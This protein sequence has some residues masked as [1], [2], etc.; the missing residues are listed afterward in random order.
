MF[1]QI[2]IFKILVS[3]RRLIYRYLLNKGKTTRK[4]D[5][6]YIV[7]LI[8]QVKPIKSYSVSKKLLFK[9]KVPNIVLKRSTLNSY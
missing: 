7:V 9:T 3:D 2:Y 4:F 6:G 5:I 8:N 1:R